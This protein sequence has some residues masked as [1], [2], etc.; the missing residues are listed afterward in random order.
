VALDYAEEGW[1]Q[2][3]PYQIKLDD[4]RLIFAPLDEDSVVREPL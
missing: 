4:G 2:P 1:K 3:A